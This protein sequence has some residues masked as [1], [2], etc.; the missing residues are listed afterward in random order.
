MTRAGGK[1]AALAAILLAIALG[2]GG[3]LTNLQPTEARADAAL[4]ASAALTDAGLGAGASAAN[5]AA[6]S[7]LA[8]PNASAPL[9]DVQPGAGGGADVSDRAALPPTQPYPPA[10][11]QTTVDYDDDD[12]GLIDVTTL[13]QLNAIRHDLNGNGDATHA[14]YVA[15]FPNRITAAGTRMGCPSGTCTGYEL[16]ADLDFDTDDDGDVDSNDDYP[17]WTPIGA[18]TAYSGEFKGNNNTISNLTV[19]ASVRYAGLFGQASGTITG[20]GLTDANVS[21]TSPSGSIGY[22]GALAGAASG[23][24]RSSYATGSVASTSSAA[25]PTNY[26]GGLI[27]Y[28]GPGGTMAA[29]WADVDASVSA[30]STASDVGGLIGAMEASASGN[31][32]VIA[33]YAHGSAA[34]TA[35][36]GTRGAGGLVGY[37]A[38]TAGSYSISASYASAIVQSTQNSGPF[39]G[40]IASSS[41]GTVTASYWDVSKSGV[42]DDANSDAPEGKT[43]SE[44]TTPTA[45]GTQ[46][47]DIYMGWNVNVDGAAGNDDPWDFGNANQYP[48]LKFD[49]MDLSEQVIAQPVDYDADDDGLIDIKTLAQLNAVRYDLNGDGDPVAAS[50]VAYEAAFPDRDAAAAG[51]MGCPDASDPADGTGDCAGY[52][53]MNDLDFD[54]D[55]SGVVD[56]DD[57]PSFPDWNPISTH[58]NKYTAEFKGNNNTISNLTI[59]TH[60]NHWRV[61]LFD[62]LGSGALVT[63]VG[64]LDV[65]LNIPALRAATLSISH[66]GALAGFNEGTI[67]SSYSTGSVSAGAP[68]P[69]NVNLGGLVGTINGGTVAASWS[70]ANVSASSRNS[71]AGGLAGQIGFALNGGTIAASY[72]TGSVT[73]TGGASSNVSSGG[74][75]GHVFPHAT[76]TASYA[77]GRASATGTTTNVGGLRGQVSDQD[78]AATLASS[79]WDTDIS[80]IADDADNNAPEGRT[81]RQLQ[82]PRPYSG[83]YRDWNVD[84]DNADTDGDL[85]TG[86][87]DPWEFGTGMQYPMLKYG[88]MSLPAQ[89]GLAM[90]APNVDTNGET[91]TVGRMARVC[92]TTGPVLR[93]AGTGGQRHKPWVWSRSADGITWTDIADDGGG[94]YEYTPVAADVN[95]Y[96]RACVAIRSSD[97]RSRGESEMCTR[98][99]P[100][101]Q[102]N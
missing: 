52:E 61:G 75:V 22:T 13:A 9:T 91:P 37:V 39:I 83:I 86:G 54:T 36:A 10:A 92:L 21:H 11:A 40:A 33:S 1:R 29:S 25:S 17:S 63:G 85:T 58:T 76:L 82:Q 15:A 50:L 18:S 68:A 46:A 60:Q 32:A 71:D 78:G 59:T 56:G 35:A 73:A 53:L 79:Y 101:A 31:V 4:S 72:A 30:G 80:G 24:I 2:F 23:T 8:A 47:T 100:A 102:S 38:A 77:A 88:G 57:S 49:S 67:R 28:L 99:F 42:A 70:S 51:R 96:L 19:S 66:A 69:G 81:A 94:T 34:N 84:I 62:T 55:G 95:N 97:A 16:R 26:V 12:D 98:P 89:G 7:G 93:Q 41:T 48:R 3:A 87:D 27:G 20:V 43:S 5:A 45:Y 65:N 74:L 64:L 14:D 44:L 6:G 90:G